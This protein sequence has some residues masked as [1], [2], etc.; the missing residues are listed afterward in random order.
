[1]AIFTQ[2]EERFEVY[3]YHCIAAT[4]I[5]EFDRNGFKNRDIIAVLGHRSTTAFKSYLQ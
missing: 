5:T 1:M 3:T 2:T 4:I